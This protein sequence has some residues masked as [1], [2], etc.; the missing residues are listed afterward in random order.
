MPRSS[1]DYALHE[2]YEK[3]DKLGRA[4][5]KHEF[6]LSSLTIEGEFSKRVMNEVKKNMPVFTGGN[7]SMEQLFS[8]K[9]DI[10]NLQDEISKTPKMYDVDMLRK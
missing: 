7:D 8:L 1:N 5:D 10:K 6:Q 4:V 9:F 3:L 2:I